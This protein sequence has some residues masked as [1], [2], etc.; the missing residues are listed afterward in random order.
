MPPRSASP[1]TGPRLA[2]FRSSR[3]LESG[4]PLSSPGLDYLLYLPDG[5]YRSFTRWP[6][7]LYL[8]GSGSAGRD[9]SR[10]KRDGM[11]RRLEE[12]E[13]I[14][15][16][17]VAPQ[18]PQIGWNVE[19]LDPL[20]HE[21]LG[22]YRVDTD[23]VYLT[24]SSMGGYGAW[25]MAAA[26]PE[27]FAAIAPICGGGDP[28]WA[29]RLRSVPTWA[30]HGADDRA[31]PTEESRTMVTALQRSGGD[32]RLTVYAEIGH[33]AWTRTYADRRLYDWLLVHRRRPVSQKASSGRGPGVP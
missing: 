28:A 26:H 13:G 20:L 7:I 5:Y 22:R 25:A 9:V 16:I 8:H 19:A 27:W 15:F 17:V 21:V 30:F 32:A 24:G 33:D 6:L 10:V 29:P 12:K 18:S 14:P 1:S 11:A 4:G 23:R 31:V 3:P 2:N